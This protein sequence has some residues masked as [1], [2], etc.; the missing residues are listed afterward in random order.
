MA[1][2]PPT[3]ASNAEL[4]RWSFERTNSHDV[5]ALREFWT[6]DTV[7]RFPDRECRGPDEIAAYFEEV[8]A[9]VPDFHMEVR[10]I[11]EHGDDVYAHWHLTGTHSGGHFQGLD[12]TGRASRSTGSTT[13]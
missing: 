10:S 7:E 5:N 11:V 2:A 1:S 3:N 6:Q 13:S 8:F 9:S 12:A 4:I